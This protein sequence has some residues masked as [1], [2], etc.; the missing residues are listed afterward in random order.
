[1]KQCYEVR[2][3]Q[4]GLIEEEGFQHSEQ[5]IAGLGGDVGCSVDIS[6]RGGGPCRCFRRMGSSQ[7]DAQILGVPNKALSET[8]K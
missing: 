6:G 2:A 3:C 1:M 8:R 5:E 7:C 4:G